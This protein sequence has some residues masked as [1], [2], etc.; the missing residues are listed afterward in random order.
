MKKRIF[1]IFILAVFMLGLLP[2]AVSADEPAL[3]VIDS[4][5]PDCYL[6]TSYDP[7]HLFVNAASPDGGTLEYIW[8]STKTPDM[9]TIMCVDKYAEFT[10]EYVAPIEVGVTYYCCGVINVKD[11]QRSDIVY[12]RLIRVE[13]TEAAPAP[14]APDITTGSLPDATAGEYYSVTLK[15]TGD[16]VEFFEYY[17]P[18]KAND[19]SKTGLTLS[20]GGKLSG[21]P[22]KAGSYT[23][24]VCAANDGGEDYASF[25][26]T[27]AEAP[28]EPEQT[29]APVPTGDT[30]VSE[31]TGEITESQPTE[32]AEPD[33]EREQTHPQADD[34]QGSNGNGDVDNITLLL[35]IIIAVAAAAL[36]ALLVVFLIMKKKQTM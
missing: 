15:A 18:G 7:A 23:F 4:T 12:S 25:T 31:P 26:L 30:E 3:P 36:I 34:K 1:A 27:V 2:T 17:N 6:D 22:T 33:E 28:Q 5:V 24:T 32:T 21:T 19:L 8:Y 29:H 16:N 20:T 14:Q 9:A 13:Y 11:G 10:A 35:I